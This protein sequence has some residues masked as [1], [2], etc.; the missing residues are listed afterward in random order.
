MS[1][2][3]ISTISLGAAHQSDILDL[4]V[5]NKYTVTVGSDGYANFWDNKQDETHNPREFA[6]RHFVNKTG[7][8]HIAHYELIHPASKFKIVVL[9]MTAFDGTGYMQYFINDDISTLQQT[10]TFTSKTTSYWSPGFYQDPMSKADY[11]ICTQADGETKV[12][13]F[14]ISAQEG[15]PRLIEI[16][17]GGPRLIVGTSFP[18]CLAVSTSEQKRLAVGY[19][20]GDVLLYDLQSLK[21]IYTFKTTDVK[22]HTKGVSNA[23]GSIPR[24][25]Q[26]LPGGLI[27]AVASDNQLAGSVTLYDAKYGEN[28]GSLTTPSHSAQA[29]GGFA[30]DGWILGLSFNHDG[31]LLATGG[32]DQCVRVWDMEGRETVA[33]ILISTSDLDDGDEKNDLDTAVVSGLQFIR[34]GVRGGLGGDN[35]EGLCVVSF[36]RGVRWYREAGGI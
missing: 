27:L 14:S 32:Y 35:N 4:V 17:L 22:Q 1:K 21:P 13:D 19:T 36:D 2:Q 6:T 5:T 11:F 18:N 7:L 26:F 10:T 24:C 29:K 30:H 34:R 16:G 23:N 12:W 20:N 33:K 25:L 8:H 9:A 15:Q 31:S 3:Y 28:V